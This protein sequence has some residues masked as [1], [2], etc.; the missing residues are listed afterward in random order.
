[1]DNDQR[2]ITG[3]TESTICSL[4]NETFICTCVQQAWLRRFG[5]LA[6]ALSHVQSQ[7][8]DYMTVNDVAQIVSCW[9]VCLPP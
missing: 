9:S 4:H 3:R 8:S 1:M 2:M 5:Q 6:V 7:S